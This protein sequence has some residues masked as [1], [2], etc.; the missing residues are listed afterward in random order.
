MLTRQEAMEAL[1]GVIHPEIDYSLVE[2]GMIG[3]LAVQDDKVNVTIKLPFP[4]IPIKDL[5]I[6]IVKDGMEKADRS[7]EVKIN[8]AVMDQAERENFR[9]KA[10]ERWKR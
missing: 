2:L 6:R 4:E 8:F 5:L 7:A 10:Q 3:E 9:G 1:S